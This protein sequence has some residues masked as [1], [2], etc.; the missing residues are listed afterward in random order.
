MERAANLKETGKEMGCFVLRRKREPW[1]FK[2]VLP[3]PRKVPREAE[4][5]APSFLLECLDDGRLKTVS[6]QVIQQ[7][8]GDVFVENKV[9]CRSSGPASEA[10]AHATSHALDP[11]RNLLG[12]D[13]WAVGIVDPHTPDR[14]CLPKFWAEHL[15]LVLDALGKERVAVPQLGHRP[16]KGPLLGGQEA[17]HFASSVCVQSMYIA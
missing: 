5:P 13:V 1:N 16:Q 17:H 15:T 9:L 4:L 8:Q 6:I 11:L 2:V 3:V 12:V 7:I 14:L 10:L